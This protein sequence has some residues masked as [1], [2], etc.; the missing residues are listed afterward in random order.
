MTQRGVNRASASAGLPGAGDHGKGSLPYPRRSRADRQNGACWPHWAEG[1][2]PGRL[3]S[4]GAESVAGAGAG[5]GK[6]VSRPVANMNAARHK[7]QG[8]WGSLGVLEARRS[9]ASPRRPPRG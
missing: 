6:R 2:M 7:G 4:T 8:A 1:E 3:G 5:A 9:R